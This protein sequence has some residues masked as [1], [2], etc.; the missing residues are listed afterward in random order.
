MRARK[1]RPDGL[2]YLYGFIDEG[3]LASG[4]LDPEGWGSTVFFYIDPSLLVDYIYTRLAVF[5][6]SSV[7]TQ[8]FQRE[9]RQNIRAPAQCMSGAFLINNFFSNRVV[10]AS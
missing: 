10:E 8:F 4:P 2:R 3:G 7:R 6:F 5:G 9:V 1:T